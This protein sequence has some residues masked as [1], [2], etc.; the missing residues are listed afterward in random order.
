MDSSR[1]KVI[2]SEA[3]YRVA[4]RCVQILGG[5]GLTN[6]TRGSQIFRDLRAFRVLYGPFEVHRFSLAR[7][8]LAGK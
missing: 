3:L 7:R 5:T 8:L 1:A 6:D 4:D 2:V